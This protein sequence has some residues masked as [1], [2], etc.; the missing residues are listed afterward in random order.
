MSDKWTEQTASSSN[1]SEFR[2]FKFK[3]ERYLLSATKPELSE[4]LNTL[5]KYV[6]N[7]DT[8]VD[9][10]EKN[11]DGDLVHKDILEKVSI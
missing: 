8:E 2:G 3:A 1:S 6:E 5:L 9:L 11:K 4:G 10:K 7:K